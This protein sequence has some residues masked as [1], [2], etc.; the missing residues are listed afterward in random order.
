[1]TTSREEESKSYKTSSL[2]HSPPPTSNKRIINCLAFSR[3]NI[4]I[5]DSSMS[6]L[7][8]RNLSENASQDDLQNYLDSGFFSEEKGWTLLEISIII[9]LAPGGYSALK[10]WP[11]PHIIWPGF[12]KVQVFEDFQHD[13]LHQF[14]LIKSSKQV[15]QEIRHI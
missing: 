15:K 10:I 2:M 6:I 12:R 11:R 5:L 14:K 1:M 8:S 9:G 4:M 13:V 7:P 3:S